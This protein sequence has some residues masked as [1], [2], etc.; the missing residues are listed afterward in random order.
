MNILAHMEIES[1]EVANKTLKETFG[2]AGKA[3]PELIWLSCGL[4]K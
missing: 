2:M 3:Q 1:N 4:E